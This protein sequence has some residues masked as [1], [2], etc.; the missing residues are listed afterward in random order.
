MTRD[1]GECV[2][3]KWTYWGLFIALMPQLQ[4]TLV[5]AFVITLFYIPHFFYLKCLCISYWQMHRHWCFMDAVQNLFPMLQYCCVV[6]FSLFNF[7]LKAKCLRGCNLWLLKDRQLLDVSTKLHP[8]DSASIER[9][10][11]ILFSL[12]LLK[13]SK[14]WFYVGI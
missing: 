12:Y 1:G 9:V 3:F 14:I 7:T 2:I 8:C 11:L 4:I 13:Y 10:H 5:W 6:E